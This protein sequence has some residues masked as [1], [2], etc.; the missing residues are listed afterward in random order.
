MMAG[1]S[2][3]GR[4]VKSLS[5]V[6]MCVLALGVLGCLYKHSLERPSRH[7]DVYNET[8]HG[9]EW[10]PRIFP[11][12]IR[13]IHEQHDLDTNEVWLSFTL[14]ATAFSP[15]AVGY[16]LV[17]E[18]ERDQLKL[19]RPYAVTWWFGELGDAGIGPIYSGPCYPEG[20]NES[21]Q[22]GYIHFQARTI[23]WWCQSQ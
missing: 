3:P 7:L 12:D 19:R 21:H 23:Y 4:I 8:L 15:E 22:R 1:V 16:T 10:I 18:S 9:G 17:P 11:Q 5:I 14:G 20:S 13:D 6:V 2:G